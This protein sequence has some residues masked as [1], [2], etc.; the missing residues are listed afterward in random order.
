MT[1]TTAILLYNLGGPTTLDEVQ[2]FLTELFCDRDI[3]ELPAGARFQTVFGRTLARLRTPAVRR[4]YRLIGGGSPLKPATFEQARL[5]ESRLNASHPENAK[6]FRVFVAMRY[7]QPTIVQALESIRDE[8][9]TRVVTLPL[10][11]HWSRA[12]TGSWRHELERVLQSFVWARAELDI[13]HVDRYPT[14]PRYLDALADTVR[15]RLFRFPPPVQP[16]VVILFSAHG[17][18]QA[19]VDRGDPYVA[20]I[21]ATRSGV[22]ERLGLSNRQVLGYQSRVGPVR[23][24]GPGTDEVIDELGREGVKH[25]LVVPLSFVSD[26]IE[27]LYEIDIL[28][29]ERAR[30]AGIESFVRT[31][32]LNAHPW[33]IEALG[34]VVE[35]H[36]AL[37]DELRG[38]ARV[39]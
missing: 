1:P 6:P 10:F 36:L 23:W 3:I 22:W 9:I 26:H 30:R 16:E 19:L 2:P 24:I 35:G 11:P 38:L 32:S 5:L 20:D 14:E 37:E 27:T 7:L 8:G 17:L 34:R 39:S 4:N 31:E 18:P 33:F 21:K 28:F 12:T 13:T 25:V 15:Q 29:A